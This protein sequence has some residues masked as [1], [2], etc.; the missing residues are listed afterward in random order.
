M[1]NGHT[2]FALCDHSGRLSTRS[3]SPTPVSRRC[4]YSKISNT[5]MKELTRARVSFSRQFRS[6]KR[7]AS[8]YMVR[9]KSL[10]ALLSLASSI[11]R[12][13][14]T[15]ASDDALSSLFFLLRWRISFSVNRHTHSHGHTSHSFFL[16][17]L[18]LPLA[19]FLS[20][21][22]FLPRSLLDHPY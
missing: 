21:S 3:P 11:R 1:A 7:S 19:F 20:L 18:S 8:S 10:F 22:P 2:Y 4:S 6:R 12:K 13:L 17:P 16:L 15:W 5:K 14:F 9:F